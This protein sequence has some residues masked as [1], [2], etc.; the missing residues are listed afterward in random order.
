MTRAAALLVLLAGCAAAP[1]WHAD[2]QGALAD[3]RAAGREVVVFFALPGRDA[4][5]RMQRALEDPAVVVALQRG[6]FTAVVAD[7]NERARL[8]EQWIGYGEGFGIAVLDAQ[9][10]VYAARPG[11]Q[12]PAELAAFVRRCVA[13]RADVA[14]AARVRTAGL[15]APM[16]QHWTGSLLLEL[17]A[18]DE[19]EPLLLDAA[20]AGVADARHRLARLY[21]QGGNLGSARRWLRDAPRT[22]P[23]LV[24]EGYVLWKE[25]RFPDAVAALDAAL[26]DDLAGDERQRALLYLG[27]VLHEARQDERAVQVL[28]AL[29][30]ENTGSVFEAAA[31]H[32]LG[33]VQSHGP[34]HDTP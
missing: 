7:G 25:R 15:Q 22:P 21:A 26:L 16:D 11:P 8:Y 6:G 3:A 24:S 10:R 28:T 4:S 14:S 19:A 9:A 33:H 5:D 29:A 17:G 20:L 27:K 18:L 13:A 31:T 23:A 2:L 32:A 1:V 12:D 34:A 30:K